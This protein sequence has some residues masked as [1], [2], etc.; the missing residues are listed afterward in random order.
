VHKHTESRFWSFGS[1]DDLNPIPNV[2]IPVSSLC[3]H[4][5]GSIPRWVSPS[6]TLLGRGKFSPQ[7]IIGEQ[8]SKVLECSRG[9]GPKARAADCC[10]HPCGSE[11]GTLG[12]TTLSCTGVRHCGCHRNRR[13]DHGEDRQQ[14]AA[15][16]EV[17]P[18]LQRVRLH[19]AQPSLARI[20]SRHVD[21]CEI[22]IGVT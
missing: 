3:D 1:R 4:A 11:A 6:N 18:T 13:A 22:R 21:L 16:G 12:R 15:S 20:D 5:V 17:S 2:S 14:M 19:R 9:R 10:Q 7:P 8:K